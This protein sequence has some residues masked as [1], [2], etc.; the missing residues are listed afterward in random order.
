MALWKVDIEK[1]WRNFYWTNRYMVQS[2][3]LQEAHVNAQQIVE[4]ER[5]IT[6]N[7]VQFTKVRTSDIFKETDVFITSLPNSAGLWLSGSN[8][9]LPLFACVRVDFSVGYGRPSRKFLRLVAGESDQD[10]GE[11]NDARRSAIATAYA[12]PLVNA[13]WFVDVDNERFTSATVAR[14]LSGRQLRRGSKRKKEPVLP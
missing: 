14:M 6:S 9:L 10:I 11:L 13:T 2:P 7:I 5:A 8:Q 4:W 12:Q 1:L 3:T